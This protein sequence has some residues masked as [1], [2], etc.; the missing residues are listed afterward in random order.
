MSSEIDSV[1]A[2]IATLLRRDATFLRRDATLLR[3]DATVSST[4][5]KRRKSDL[6][7]IAFRFLTDG[8]RVGEVE[9]ALHT[10]TTTTGRAGSLSPRKPFG[11]VVR[12]DIVFRWRGGFW[13]GI[14]PGRQRETCAS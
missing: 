4:F 13:A 12:N 2:Q 7:Q 10:Q 6:R 3:H 11:F 5:V 8:V 1:L 14:W 9:T